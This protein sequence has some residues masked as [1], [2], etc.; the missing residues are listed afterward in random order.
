[1]RR[2]GLVNGKEL[3][4]VFAEF[5]EPLDE[6][7][8][9]TAYDGSRYFP[10]EVYEGCLNEVVGREN[11]DLSFPELRVMEVGQGVKVTAL[12]E[13]RIYDISGEV[14][15]ATSKWGGANLN[16]SK[17][18]TEEKF[19]TTVQQAQS[20]ALVAVIKSFSVG[21]AQVRA[22]KQEQKAAAEQKAA[23]PSAAPVKS[24]QDTPAGEKKSDAPEEVRVWK[25]RLLSGP[26]ARSGNYLADCVDNDGV[27][28][29][30]VMKSL[31][32]EKSLEKI[33]MKLA[34]FLRG[35]RPGTE[36][37]IEGYRKVYNGVEEIIFVRPA[38]GAS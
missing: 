17:A 3:S 32:L 10:V 8:M 6:N 13:V 22:A 31:T 7:L 18:G 12:C 9:K 23:R 15:C 38:G 30:L 20:Y 1:M 2:N 27:K 25:I 36:L 26:S 11:Y 5:A 35:C 24:V 4:Q 37:N 34:D 16:V 19:N 29:R 33:G 14:V 28:Y 21:M